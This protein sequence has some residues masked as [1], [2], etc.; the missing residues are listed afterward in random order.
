MKRVVVIPARLDSTRLKN[1]LLLELDG[2]SII[3]RVYEQCL[4]STK[5]EKVFIAVDDQK[6]KDHCQ[7]F[8]KNVIITSKHHQS[9]TDRIAEAIQKIDCDVVINVQGDEPFI[10]PSLIDQL[11]D[12]FNDDTVK[13]CSAMVKITSAEAIKNPNNVKVVTDKNLNA[14]YFSRQ[15]IPFYREGKQEE[16]TQDYFKHIGIYGYKKPFIQ[17]FSK[18]NQTPLE[19]AEKL[20]QL[21]V[22]ENGHNIKMITTQHNSIGIDTLEDYKNAQLKFMNN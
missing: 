14:L 9:G 6:L 18:M 12:C 4:L 5:I 2:K 16:K 8:S 3:Q 15:A 13:M 21:R 17:K 22:L 7:T 19:N 20:E 11:S 10:D 1:K